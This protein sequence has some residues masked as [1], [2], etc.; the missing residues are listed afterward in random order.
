MQAL[1]YL[2]IK[3]GVG[4]NFSFPRGGEQAPAVANRGVRKERYLA[5]LHRGSFIPVLFFKIS[6]YPH[7]HFCIKVGVGVYLSYGKKNEC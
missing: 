2:R 1:S 4:E 5:C 3:K 7:T 6:V